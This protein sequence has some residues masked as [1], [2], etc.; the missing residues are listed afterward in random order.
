MML[1]TR[2]PVLLSFGGGGADRPAVYEKYG[3]FV[4]GFAINYYV[5]VIL[6]PNPTHRTQIILD[7]HMMCD[8]DS[9]DI[10]I[11]PS[12]ALAL[13][14]AIVRYFNICDDLT[15]FL[16]SQVPHC[17]ALGWSGS[18]GVSMTKAIALWCGLDL[19]ALDV[20][21][22]T[23]QIQV[24]GIGAVWGWQ[25]QYT[26]ALGGLN[27][28]TFSRKGVQLESL[29]LSPSNYKD[30]QRNLLLFLG[31]P[32]KDMAS[33]YDQGA[34]REFSNRSAVL[35][36]IQQYTYH[37]RDAIQDGNL[38]EFSILLHQTWLQK[39]KLNLDSENSFWDL[40]YEDA[41]ACG[42]T[43]G[44]VNG[45]GPQK[46]LILFCPVPYQSAVIEA[47]KHRGLQHLPFVFESQGVQVIQKS[48]MD[49]QGMF[50]G[51]LPLV[52]MA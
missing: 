14:K 15:I 1:I 18:V 30:L 47:L 38:M 26:A 40:C 9:A 41:R 6:T 4:I 28:I 45:I 12:L 37:M 42:A 44:T 35:E 19:A 39:R 29:S 22:M 11:N 52:E 16:A 8:A 25:S 48:S 49:T 23:S 3:G 27:A 32:P 2:A 7:G 21:E 46:A 5:Y 50:D 17:L 31:A 24:D 43:G 34:Q 51:V 20:A 33:K 10:E 36:E 13:P